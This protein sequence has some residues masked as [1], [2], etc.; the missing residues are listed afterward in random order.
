[1]RLFNFKEKYYKNIAPRR[2]R[3]GKIFESI[4]I[5]ILSMCIIME[6]AIWRKTGALVNMKHLFLG[7]FISIVCLYQ[8][9]NP[10]DSEYGARAKTLKQR[11]Y[12]SRGIRILAIIMALIT[13]MME[14]NNMD[15][16]A[17]KMADIA[18]IILVGLFFTIWTAML[19]L[20]RK[21]K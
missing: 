9:Y 2:T 4:T 12:A 15:V 8:A 7:S 16:I 1:M 20:I 14:L 5:L 21:I 11:L 19:F 17:E 6:L 3:E 10:R 13:F 18:A